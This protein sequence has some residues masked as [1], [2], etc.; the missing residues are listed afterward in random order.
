MLHLSMLKY[1][2]LR[3]VLCLG[4]SI[5]FLFDILG[6]IPIAQAQDFR[7]QAPGMM[8]YLSPAFNPPLLK[9]IKV[10]PDNPFRFDFILDKGDEKMRHPERSEGSQQV[11][12]KTEA[13]KLIKYFLVSLT[14]PEKDLW[15]NLSP[16]EKDRIIPASFGQTEMGRDL[17]AEDYMLKQITASLIYPEGKT[18][19]KFWNRIYK[20]AAK[21]FGTT[22]IPV[23]TFNKV[24]IVPETAVVYENPKA[25]TA[26]V[27]ES[28][29]KVM[30][31]QDYL[32]LYKNN[33]GVG[34][35]P[36]QERAGYEPA[37]TDFNQLGSTI[38]RANPATSKLSE[39]SRVSLLAKNILQAI[40][41]PELTKEVNQDE[42]FAQLR[43]V[44]NSLI[45]A[46]WYKKKI[47][48]SILMQVYADKNKVS[49]VG[50]INSLPP[51]GR[52][53]EGDVESI[54]Q[55]YLQAFKKGAYNYIKEEIDPQTQQSVSR[56][57]FSGGF[58]GDMAMETFSSRIP[59]SVDLNNPNLIEVT[60]D[61]A[62]SSSLPVRSGDAAMNAAQ[63]YHALTDFSHGIS[64]LA[65]L[66]V[67]FFT[68]RYLWKAQSRVINME[69][70]K[71]ET[72]IEE[73][74]RNI[75]KSQYLNSTWGAIAHYRDDGPVLDSIIRHSTNQWAVWM[76]MDRLQAHPRRNKVILE[77]LKGATINGIPNFIAEYERLNKSLD[78]FLNLVR[79]SKAKLRRSGL[80]KLL[81]GSTDKR[82]DFTAEKFIYI[83]N[84]ALST[85][86]KDLLFEP[87]EG[88]LSQFQV[89][90]HPMTTTLQTKS[91]WLAYSIGGY[92]KDFVKRAK[93][94]SQLTE[95]PWASAIVWAGIGSHT[96]FLYTPTDEDDI[97]AETHLIN[98][99][100][101]TFYNKYQELE[102][103]RAIGN[104][105]EAEAVDRDVKA[106]AGALLNGL[107]VQSEYYVEEYVKL[108][109]KSVK[110][111]N[112]SFEEVIKIALNQFPVKMPPFLH[113]VDGLYGNE[114]VD[115]LVHYNSQNHERLSVRDILTNDSP[116]A[117]HYRHL[118]EGA[119]RRHPYGLEP[120][121]VTEGKYALLRKLYLTP[122]MTSAP[123]TGY[124]IG[125]N[126]DIDTAM[127]AS[128]VNPQ[129]SSS[130]SAE[131][132]GI[133]LTATKVIT[134]LRGSQEI[135]FHIDPAQLAAFQNAPGFVPVIIYMRPMRNIR[136]F[137]GMNA[138]PRVGH[139]A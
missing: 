127:R 76:A 126:K 66:A 96:R 55:R 36:T 125:E 75:N 47:R 11:Q 43:Q 10:H 137:L 121:I 114:V 60:S 107:L 21:K 16:Y 139:I 94:L 101:G 8:A 131:R 41:I 12:L 20:E 90:N 93:F 57:Y 39:K 99:F 110:P 73:I 133:D 2:N 28:K 1:S 116:E 82:L 63:A 103:L 95:M 3:Q 13:S 109:S 112:P 48:D 46:T 80:N 88:L 33:V 122:A 38:I 45:L 104:T 22:N 5:A 24:W 123:E 52:V 15:V 68:A 83:I 51:V 87:I 40:V 108:I 105:T 58:L 113:Y 92:H 31:E 132:G 85:K 111:G 4:L 37:P 74:I 7:L 49:G 62:L 129:G 27:V 98:G 69:L 54:Y 102:R 65:F 134:G 118:V 61:L 50:Y 19:K 6:P 84:M 26:Y 35:K 72:T 128:V 70:D 81:E 78:S 71:K 135:R 67:A 18:G 59:S 119:N 100:I 117:D 120:I 86:Y 138:A 42:N 115:D 89:L 29:L 64:L 25:G 136:G 91:D 56:K 32:A 53:R 106:F 17:L 79:G 14:I 9:G 130:Q 34:S 77:Q 30:L 97:K 44:Y 124:G 23:N